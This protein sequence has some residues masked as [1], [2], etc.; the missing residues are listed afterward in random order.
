MRQGWSA[1]LVGGVAVL[2]LVGPG[3]VVSAAQEGVTFYED[4]L[5]ILQ[6]NCQTCHR[7]AG[8]E[9]I[10]G[11][12]APMALETYQ[13][14]RPWAR[15]IR[16]KVEAREMPP[17]FAT[18]H[19]KGL[20]Y[21]ERGLSDD[22][23]AL[24]ARWEESGAPAGDPEDAP[25]PTV[26]ADQDSGGWSL[27]TPDLVVSLPEPYLV[28]DDVND[29][30]ITFTTIVPED[31]LSAGVW[32]QGIEFKSG[33]TVVHHVCAAAIAPDMIETDRSGGASGESSLGCIAPG[34]E[35]RLL[36][37]GFGFYCQR[38]WPF[39]STCITTRSPAQGRARL[40]TR[41][42]R[43]SLVMRRSSIGRSSIRF[44]TPGSRSL[45]VKS[46]GRLGAR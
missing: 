25:P 19:T 33:S 28:E 34:A 31:Q 13:Q 46:A 36:P 2:G 30:N 26:F 44:R 29:K 21:N 5:P 45:L 24:L 38:V 27:G 39:D 43:S 3:V 12:V 11:T 32:V 15:S 41:R 18:D 35:S 22:E 14:T 4:V 1:A 8:G 17:W 42:S 16:R 7:D 9:N 23:I 37:D 6:E 40:T 20:F 10:G